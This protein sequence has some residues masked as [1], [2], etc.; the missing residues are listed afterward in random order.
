MKRI[1]VSLFLIFIIA[2]AMFA[3][4]AQEE[5]AIEYNFGWYGPAP[6]PFFETSIL[7]V[8]QFTDELG[9]E[10]D[11][12]IGPDWNQSSETMNVQAMAAKGIEYFAICPA[13]PSSAN[14]L[15]EELSSNGFPVVGFCIPTAEPSSSEFFIGTD[16]GEAAR[17]AAEA[18]IEQMG[19]KGKILNILEMLSDSNTIVRKQAIEEVVKKYP[20]VEI[21]QEIA[22]MSTVEEATRKITDA[23]SN[24]MD[25]INGMITTGTTT[26]IAMANV[27]SDYYARGGQNEIKAV[28][29]D[30]DE[31]ILSAIDEG[32][33]TATLAQNPA[34]MSYLACYVMKYLADGWVKREGV[35]YI[36]SGTVLVTKENIDAFE[37]DIQEMTNEIRMNLETIYLQKM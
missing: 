27:L 7:G 23:V 19:G 25:N 37:E 1:T 2:T 14:S 16:V 3:G 9:I 22:D 35:Y 6:H 18:L 31:T 17:Q 34:G 28:G 24:N 12:Q 11:V 10:V 26:T 5:Q 15:Y 13:D 30:Y 21:V 36:N 4:G 32:L 8:E 33:L 29:I 20:G